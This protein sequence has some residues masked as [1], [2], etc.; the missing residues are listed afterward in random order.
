[1]VMTTN[2]K[3]IVKRALSE[4]I[5]TGDVAA[6]E[7]FLRDDFVHHRP[8]S[9][10]SKAQWLA[11]VQAVPLAELQ[12]EIHHLLA[13]GDHVVMHSRRWLAG[14]GQEI[15]GVDIWRLEDGLIVEGWEILEPP[16]DAAAHMAW[17]QSA[18]AAVNP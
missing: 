9:T 17:W 12:V 2:N 11:A 18:P 10:S 6:L 13:D 3:L 7:T 1:M 8:N 15:V 4:L 16:A 5:R 14:A